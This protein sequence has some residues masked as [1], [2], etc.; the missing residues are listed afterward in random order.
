MNGGGGGGPNARA[1][2]F[3]SQNQ[4]KPSCV[5]ACFSPSRRQRDGAV[6]FHLSLSQN[7]ISVR[8]LVRPAAAF[9]A[10]Q[11]LRR[12]AHRGPDR[13]ALDALVAGRTRHAAR[14]HALALLRATLLRLDLGV[15]AAHELVARAAAL[16]DDGRERLRL[17]DGEV[18]RRVRVD[19]ASR[20]RAA[21]GELVGEA[22]ADRVRQGLVV[23]ASSAGDGDRGRARRRDEANAVV[24]DL[25]GGLHLGG[26]DELDRSAVLLLLLLHLLLLRA[27]GGWRGRRRR[28]DGVLL[29]P[30]AR[31]RR[32]RHRALR[33]FCL[34]LL[35]V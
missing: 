8:R 10:A 12:A 17:R 26:R 27:Q 16:E 2:S 32:R 22:G 21:V 20:G 7:K 31:Q 6:S 15:G 18:A 29:L 24:A 30:R 19:A 11:A 13:R 9:V 4:K 5:R 14:L 1:F 33:V 3:S 28:A 23:A 34:L 25:H 35:L